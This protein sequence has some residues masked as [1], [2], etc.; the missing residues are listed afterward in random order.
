[1]KKFAVVGVYGQGED[2]TTG[3]A[4][5]CFELINWLNK[6]YT[7]SNVMIVNTYKWKKRPL[8]LFFSLILAFIQCE[9]VIIMPAQNG[10]KIFAPLSYYL[11]KI[12]KKRVQ[13]IVIGGWLSETLTENKQLKK[14]VSSFDGVFVETNSMVDKL[15]KIGVVKSYYL[16]NCR[17]VPKNIKRK[18]YKKGEIH[19]LCTYSRV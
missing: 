16:P 4:V 5:K 14:F 3:Q 19:K 17:E 6:T 18:N 2:F 7:K 8:K 11:K 10:L 9:N 13:Y 1:M 12:F 15:Q